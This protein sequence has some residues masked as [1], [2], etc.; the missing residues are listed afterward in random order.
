V[1]SQF[2]FSLL[3]VLVACQASA[4]D[5]RDPSPN[6]PTAIRSQ[7]IGTSDLHP[8]ARCELF[9]ESSPRSVPRSGEL[10]RGVISRATKDDVVL[11]NATK[12]RW[13][14]HRVPILGETPI[15]GRFFRYCTTAEPQD[16]GFVRIAT[17]NV[18]S[19]EI[20]SGSKK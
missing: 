7:R 20:G 11:T 18:V 15:L 13:V 9:V 10:Y 17:A 8:G 1:K 14:E 19:I 3:A 12:E 5:P 6:A 2:A 16:V 4:E